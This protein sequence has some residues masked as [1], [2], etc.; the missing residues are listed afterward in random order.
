[1]GDCLDDIEKDADRLALQAQ[2]DDGEWRSSQASH[3]GH[4]RDVRVL[5]KKLRINPAIVAGR[6]R[7][8]KRNY[9]ALTRFVGLG[10][11]RKHFQ[12]ATTGA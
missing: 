10:E 7:H 8:E 3:T 5:A 9:R 2:I 12:E 6:V 1:M 11:V 4:P